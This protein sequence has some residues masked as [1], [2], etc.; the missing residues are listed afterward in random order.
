MLSGSIILLLLLNKFLGEGS[1][2]S[3]GII[4][5]IFWNH[6][7]WTESLTSGWKQHYGNNIRGHYPELYQDYKNISCK[8]FLEI[9]DPI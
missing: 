3:L 6:P 9:L 8:H 1:C 2:T 7:L 4:V 5:E